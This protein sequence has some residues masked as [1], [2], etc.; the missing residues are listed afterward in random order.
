MVK[1]TI[2]QI[3]LLVM[4]IILLFSTCASFAHEM[5]PALG[6]LVVQKKGAPLT[7]TL[8]ISGE[9]ILAGIDLGQY[10]NTENAPNAEK[11]NSLRALTVGQVTDQLLQKNNELFN[12]LR[13][14]SAQG[15]TRF[16]LKSVGINEV[17]NFELARIARLTF[18]APTPSSDARLLWPEAF[19]D[20]VLKLI[21]PDGEKSVYLQAGDASPI[22]GARQSAWDVFTGYITVGFEH[23]VPKG[24][25]HILFVLGLFLLSPR[26]Q[27]L[28]WQISAFTLAHTVTLALVSTG[29]ISLSSNI[30]EPL[31][32]LSIVAVAVEN[33]WRSELSR[34][35]TGLVFAFGLLHGM[36]FASVLGEWGLPQNGFWPALIGF[37]IGVEI[38]QLTIVA[39][40][41]L[42]LA[43]PFQTRLFYRPMITL[44]LS[45]LI[46]LIG[47]YW[48]IERIFGF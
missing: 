9:A 42:A 34:W 6:E 28:L 10:Q 30:V 47:L 12:D 32:A 45:G 27:A 39:L 1:K 29:A 5:N 26:W 18:E 24:L 14:S 2:T 41:W 38:G 31:I 15:E 8:E 48:A 40:A 35:R 7:F 46:A 44:P 17:E 19:G 25:D 23:I 13:L 11:Y 20:L 37:N 36:G 21:T 4:V 22:I 33:F 16:T 3:R 43:L